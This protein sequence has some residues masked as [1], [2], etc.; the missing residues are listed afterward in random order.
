MASLSAEQIAQLAYQAGFRGEDLVNVV[1]IA[2]RESGY[3]T[4]S[5]NGN[6]GTGDK[7]YGLMQINMIGNLG[8]S[9]LRAFGI[10]SNEQLFDPLTNMKAA[11]VLYQQSGNKLTPWG[12][13]KGFSNTYSTNV[14][15]ARTAVESAQS[16]GLLGQDWNGGASVATPAVNPQAGPAQSAPMA[17]L[18]SDARIVS[19]GGVYNFALFDLGAGVTISYG[20]PNDGTINWSAA[21]AQQITAE[22]WLSLNTVD[23][24]HGA[25]LGTVTSTFG[26]YK[27][28]WDSIVGQVMGN[29]PAKD[30]PDV[31]RILA[32]YA[33]RPDMSTA[34]LENKLTATAWY[35]GRTKGELDWND[36]SSAEQD[37]RR[38]DQSAEM[39]KSVFQY[40]GVQA[41]ASNPLVANYVDQ[42]ASGKLGFGNWLE[43]VVKPHAMDNA[44]SPWARQVRD[45][46]ETQR[47]RP[48]DIENTASKVRDMAARWGV[49]W[50]EEE[51][52]RWGRNIVEKSASDAD[53][54]E[55]LKSQAAI[56]FPWKD[57]ETETAVAAAP[58]VETYKRVMETSADLFDPNIQKALTA[59]QPLWDFEKQ[60]KST[61]G[62]LKTKNARADMSNMADAIGKK[63]GFTS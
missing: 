1:A 58:W 5:F 22:E 28:F 13:Y 33:G 3:N 39:A 16:K 63:M 46:T 34:E 19:V 49:R 47:Q 29:N 35:Q 25:E 21:N 37:K 27:N 57:R 41:D 38:Q 23:G 55:A 36:L 50:S 60:L 62:W 12:G 17:N 31:R 26:S 7:S 24:G 30:D 54:L 51:Y 10:T 4:Q 20:L 44:E 40:L 53:L 43:T 45:E 42:I 6:T 11:Y 9:R 15:A 56:L 48:V 18:P 59:G 52:Q 2:K 61:D 8:P 32:E 14:G